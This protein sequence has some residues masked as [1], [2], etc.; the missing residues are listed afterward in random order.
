MY[1]NKEVFI[2]ILAPG[3][4]KCNS[5]P[6][7]G[8]IKAKQK[9]KQKV[10]K[11]N[12]AIRLNSVYVQ[13]LIL[14]AGQHTDALQIDV[15]VISSKG[16]QKAHKQG[17]TSTRIAPAFQ[18]IICAW[19]SGAYKLEA[20]LFYRPLKHS[21]LILKHVSHHHNVYL[22]FTQQQRTSHPA[23]SPSLPPAPGQRVF[24]WF[25]GAKQ[26]NSNQAQYDWWNSASCCTFGLQGMR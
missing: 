23:I 12:I 16:Q 10:Q 20:I 7:Q 1:F 8:F 24:I 25:P 2:Q 19:A 17:Q 9:I 14:Q 21:N 26:S 15:L 13:A 6:H 5:M 3:L 18:E 11:L 22:S 4:H